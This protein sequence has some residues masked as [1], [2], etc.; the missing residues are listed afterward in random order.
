MYLFGGVFH[1]EAANLE[2]LL[3]WDTANLLTQLAG[4]KRSLARITIIHQVR[5]LFER[6]KPG[7][8]RTRNIGIDQR[9]SD[10]I[11]GMAWNAETYQNYVGN[12][13]LY[14]H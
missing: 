10:G 9:M 6:L 2:I 1:P 13:V 14:S 4:K 3:K 8:S 11:T 5:L 7:G 12:S